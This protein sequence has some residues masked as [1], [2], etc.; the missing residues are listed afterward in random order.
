M[1]LNS[2]NAVLLNVFQTLN[3]Y[4]RF[5]GCVHI[6]QMLSQV[7]QNANVSSSNSAVYLTIQK[8]THLIIKGIKKYQNE[9]SQSVHSESIQTFST[10]CYVTALF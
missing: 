10:F 2:Q 1:Q 5:I 3:G 6:L 9:L 7:Q 4:Q 8:N